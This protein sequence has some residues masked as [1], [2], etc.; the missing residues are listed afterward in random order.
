MSPLNRRAWISASIISSGATLLA[1]DIAGGQQL[2]NRT[3][4]GTGTFTSA[5]FSA[6]GKRL[7]TAAYDGT[8]QLWNVETGEQVRSYI[9]HTETVYTV[10]F[11]AGERRIVTASGREMDMGSISRDSS[12]RVWDTE[13]G[14]EVNRLLGHGG[15]VY[16]AIFSP[17]GRHVLSSARDS[18]ARIWDLE[19]SRELHKFTGIGFLRPAVFSPDGLQILAI[20]NTNAPFR[21]RLWSVSSGVEVAR[22]EGHVGEIESAQFSPDG[23][24]IVTASRDSTVRIWDP[25]TGRELQKIA[26]HDGPV[27]SAIFNSDGNTLLTASADGKARLWNAKDGSEIRRFSHR[28][29]VRQ[30]TLNKNG[31]RLLTKWKW[32]GTQSTFASLWDADGGKEI[33][34][35]PLPKIYGRDIAMFSPDGK[36]VLI[37]LA[38][39]TLLDAVTGDKLREFD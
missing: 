10:T 4:L 13:T 19:T 33:M 25:Q 18:T 6:N 36:Q 8:A 39:T 24:T 9:G 3:T 31:N 34:Q 17:D 30:A 16:S 5:V 11:S 1:R 27:L 2:G 7:L 21:A 38:K 37:T 12:V 29:E 14:K 35:C 23:S 32:H 22:L 26:G 15:Y 20:E 28:G